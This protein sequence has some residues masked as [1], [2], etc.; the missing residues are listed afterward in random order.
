MNVDQVLKDIAGVT[1]RFQN[2]T[3]QHKQEM[4]DILAELGVRGNLRDTTEQKLKSLYT[5]YINSKDQEYKDWMQNSPSEFVAGIIGAV[6][7]RRLSAEDIRKL[8][9]WMEEHGYKT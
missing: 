2:L 6:Q 1:N 4:F 8:I 9:I 7:Q 3:N 5:T